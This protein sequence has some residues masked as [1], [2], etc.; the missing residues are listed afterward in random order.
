MWVER[1]LYIL[2]N[3]LFFCVMNMLKTP[4]L[5]DK[6]CNTLTKNL[7]G[8]VLLHNYCQFPKH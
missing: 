7:Y 4:F 2:I 3:T 6:S 8:D 1:R 5:L